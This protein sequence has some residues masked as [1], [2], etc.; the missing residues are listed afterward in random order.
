MDARLTALEFFINARFTSLES[1]IVVALSGHVM[2]MDT[3]LAIGFE[4]FQCE[5]AYTGGGTSSRD[6]HASNVE[7]MVLP[8][9]LTEEADRHSL[10][11][12]RH[13]WHENFDGGG[14]TPRL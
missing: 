13:H 9:I 1:T 8:L 14:F 5:L 11:T 4:Q 7:L 12:P 2:A 3:K 6:T 10:D